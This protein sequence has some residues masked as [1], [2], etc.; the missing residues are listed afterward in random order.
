MGPQ[1]GFPGTRSRLSDSID[2]ARVS[3]TVITVPWPTALESISSPLEVGAVMFL[4]T[5]A[6]RVFTIITSSTQL[7]VVGSRR[8]FPSRVMGCIYEEVPGLIPKHTK[9][10]PRAV[11]PP[12]SPTRHVS[13]LRGLRQLRTRHLSF[14]LARSREKSLLVLVHCGS[15]AGMRGASTTWGSAAEFHIPC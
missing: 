8:W 4:Y 5:S 11:T 9:G 12:S 13:H 15:C 6:Y 3:T 10:T 14:L 1:F 2:Y 7:H